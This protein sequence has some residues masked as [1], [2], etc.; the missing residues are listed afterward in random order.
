MGLV[1]AMPAQPQQI[2]EFGS[3]DGQVDAGNRHGAAKGLAD[4]AQL[5]LVHR[6]PET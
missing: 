5:K 4:S 1:R 6:Y 2:H 3:L